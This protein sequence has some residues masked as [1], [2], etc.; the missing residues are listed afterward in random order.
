MH[1]ALWVFILVVIEELVC[2][3]VCMCVFCAGQNRQVRLNECSTQTAVGHAQWLTANI[4][5]VMLSS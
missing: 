4:L 1:L 5:P 2:V 3:F